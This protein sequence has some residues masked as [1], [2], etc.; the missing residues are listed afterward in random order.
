M[1]VFVESYLMSIG[2]TYF[3]WP[4]IRLCQKQ[5]FGDILKGD[6][7]HFLLRNINIL[8]SVVNKNVGCI[9]DLQK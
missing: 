6:S 2:T 8:C 9:K 5:F 1:P 4:L 7:S 3:L